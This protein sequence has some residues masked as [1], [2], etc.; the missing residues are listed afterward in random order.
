MTNT[1]S[2]STVIEFAI[3][4]A[5]SPVIAWAAWVLVSVTCA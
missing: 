1:S 5:L 4:V 3:P 2:I